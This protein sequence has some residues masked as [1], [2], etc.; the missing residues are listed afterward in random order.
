MVRVRDVAWA[1]AAA[2]VLLAGTRPAS[3]DP[4]TLTGNVATD[5][6]APTAA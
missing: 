1:L 2:A 5:F 3:A 4:I 6:T